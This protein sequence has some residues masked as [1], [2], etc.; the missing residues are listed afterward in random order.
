MKKV[1][2]EKK[3]GFK[4]NIM[5][6]FCSLLHNVYQFWVKLENDFHLDYYED[7]LLY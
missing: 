6:N 4:Y 7:K 5:T 3:M 1:K 2:I